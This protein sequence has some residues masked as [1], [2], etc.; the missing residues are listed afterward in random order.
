MLS[1]L[2]IPHQ[3]IV[4]LEH[5][6]SV[7]TGLLTLAKHQIL[8]A[9]LVLSPDLEDLN[10]GDM[11]PSLLGWLDVSDIL[12]A[13]IAHLERHHFP[14]P[15]KMLAL[16]TL[17]EKEAPQWAD[18]T[19]LVTISGGEDKGLV[20]QTE[21]SSTSVAT[22]IREVFL[23]TGMITRPDNRVTHRLAAFNDTGDIT[24]IISQLDIMRFLYTH[25]QELGP[26]ADK[27][28]IEVGLLTGRPPVFT[29]DPHV[30][31]LLAFHAM[32]QQGI[33]GAP[34][35]TAEGD[36]VANISISDLR[37]LTPE[38]FGVLALPVAEFLAVS[39]GTAYLG[40]ATDKQRHP[41]FGSDEKNK[42]EDI[43]LYMVTPTATL[44]TLL[45]RL[46]TKHIHR[47]YVVEDE[48]KPK[49]Q[50]ILTPTDILRLVSGFW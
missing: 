12:R 35:V 26:I 41:F 23:Q 16:M 28:I 13:L 40:Y 8:S 37:S 10:A 11:S 31:T 27:S 38:H 47:V 15:T 22:A 50:A 3:H 49:V 17:L 2:A 21:A 46:V 30:P 34:V 29:V 5:D 32:A 19:T 45:E 33:S 6:M 25:S 36:L 24:A 48:K 18:S 39:H 20:Y 1:Q 9:P 7:R 44:K 14:V 43:A 4:L 42:G